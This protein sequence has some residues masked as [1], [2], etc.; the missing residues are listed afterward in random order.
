[1]L[2]P[3]FLIGLVF[4]FLLFVLLGF[5]GLLSF[6]CELWLDFLILFLNM[7]VFVR[8]HLYYD[9]LSPM[10]S[11][12]VEVAFFDSQSPPFATLGIVI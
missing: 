3:S 8:A 5:T 1:M 10:G 6:I 9:L 12:S 4:F 7:P 11:S 2:P